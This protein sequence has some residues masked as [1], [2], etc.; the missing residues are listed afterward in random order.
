MGY[1]V[2]CRMGSSPLIALAKQIGEMRAAVRKEH[3]DVFTNSKVVSTC[4]HFVDRL[5]VIKPGPN[6]QVAAVEWEGEDIL[7]NAG[8]AKKRKRAVREEQEDPDYRGPASASKKTNAAA[9]TKTRRSATEVAKPASMRPAQ[10]PPPPAVRPSL[11]GMDA[12][13]PVQRPTQG[14]QSFS[15][16]YVPQTQPDPRAYNVSGIMLDGFFDADSLLS[17]DPTE[18]MARRLLSP[19]LSILPLSSTTPLEPS[20]KLSGLSTPTSTRQGGSD[21]KI[22]LCIEGRQEEMGLAGLDGV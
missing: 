13:H 14:G 17:S 10:P 12:A 22:D 4:Y 16:P 8:Q 21:G 9:A 20:N 1:L 2:Y 19:L 11:S 6:Q 7:D 18:S 15:S 3:K 5:P